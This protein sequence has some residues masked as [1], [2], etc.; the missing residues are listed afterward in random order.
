MRAIRQHEFGP[1]DRLVPEDLP[2]LVPGDWEVRIAVEAAGVHLIDTTIR[3]GVARGP[4][5]LPE[6]PMTPGR[7]VAGTVD[8]IGPGVDES[9]LGRRVVG[10]LGMA[11]GGYASQAVAE[12][13]SLYEIPDGLD[14]AAAVAMI[15]S[16]RTATGILD[17]AEIEPSD[18]VVVTAAAG[19]MGTLFVQEAAGIGATVVGLAGGADKVAIVRDLGAD[20]AIDYLDADWPAQVRVAVE[21]L[22]QPGATV[23]L[24][25]VGGDAGRA[26]MELLAPG[27]RLVMF[28]WASGTPLDLTTM[29]LYRTGITATVAIG[30]RMLASPGGLAALEARALEA[31]ASGRWTP[32]IGQRFALDDAASAHDAL[33][34]RATVG[35]VVLVPGLP[36][37]SVAGAA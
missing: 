20:V 27:G 26:A 6:L 17:V 13:D 19:G 2:D 23:V 29:D 18:V 24:D 8:A 22:G 28:G 9:W 33:E 21:E 31:A 30:A 15:G 4:M 7:E 14:A 1:A 35:K 36:S 3:Q 32:L 11:N 5:P 34:R 25:G 12:T 37:E 10:H 16:G